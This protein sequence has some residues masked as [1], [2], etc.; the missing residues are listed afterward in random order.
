VPWL[1]QMA[2]VPLT[3]HAFLDDKMAVGLSSILL[4]IKAIGTFSMFAMQ[5]EVAKNK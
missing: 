1:G 2:D 5:L 4:V 3:D